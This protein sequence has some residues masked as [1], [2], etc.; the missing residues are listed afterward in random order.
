MA[1]DTDGAAFGRAAR[2]AAEA[3]A[4]LAV[5]AEYGRGGR[6]AALDALVGG[7]AVRILRGES[8]IEVAPLEQGRRRRFVVRLRGLVADERALVDEL[9][10]VERQ[11]S[12]GAWFL[13][14]E[15]S[16]KTRL[17]DFPA[18]LAR[19]GESAHNVLDIAAAER[20]IAPLAVA[21][22][23]VLVWALLQPLVEA[24][25]APFTLR[26]H[27]SGGG[28]RDKRL[29]A[30]RAIAETFADLG[31]ALDASLAV[32]RPGA[33]WSRLRAEEQQAH[34][35]ALAAAM[36]AQAT[37]ALGGR[38]RAAR[39]C[40]LVAQHAA[41]ARATGLALRGQ[42]VTRRFE[43]T[44]AGFFG[45][46]WLAFLDYLGAR[47]HPDE[48]IATALPEPRLY[49]G[50]EQPM[51]Q[52]TPAGID[53][54]QLRLMLQALYGDAR[55]DSPV[56]RRVMVLRR[57][58][59]AFD[60]LHAA[61][62]P[63]LP[64][65]WGL[66]P[67]GADVPRPDDTWSPYQDGLY[68][69][70]LPADL[71]REIEECWGAALLPARPERI[72][73][74]ISA[75]AL[76]AEAF[77]PALRFWHGCA[78]TAWFL[79]EGPMSRTDMAG[80]AAYHRAE[81]AALD[82]LGTPVD[83]TLFQHLIAA[84]QHLG[85]PVPLREESTEVPSQFG[86]LRMTTSF[87]QRRPGFERLRDVITAARRA[88]AA[89]HLEAYLRARAEGD[90]GA[91]ARRYQVRT[92]ERGIKPPTPKQ[93]ARDAAPAANRWFGGDLDA[94][95]RAIGEKPLVQPMRERLMPADRRA[96][97]RMLYL[98]LGGTIEREEA[99]AA[100]RWSVP[101]H[102][103]RLE[104]NRQLSDLAGRGLHYIQ[105]EEGLGRRPRVDEFGTA[106]FV[107]RAQA[108]DADTDRAWDKY[109]QATALMR[110][111]E[112]AETAVTALSKATEAERATPPTAAPA[113]PSPIHEQ[114]SQEPWWRRVIGA[115]RR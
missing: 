90:V 2:E 5:E 63:G 89:Q 20:A 104:T 78:L 16:I 93:F 8:I 85:A 19:H 91:A 113:A 39:L 108:L 114:G 81:L 37:P 52:A 55:G 107:T 75:H 100:G 40:P 83:P 102:N 60:A 28:E 18:Q 101:G 24:L 32:L 17:L 14:D 4:L 31:F 15:A 61:Q 41:K 103:E 22:D 74:A 98:A 11:Q 44:L 7:L 64:P 38:Y 76:L 58:W 9:F 49:L 86:M 73:S 54:A 69:R 46:D 96:F 13:P 35:R 33:G 3:A 53:E 77:G 110:G 105:L 94:L 106:W 84:E 1:T 62:R 43:P 97:V 111:A 72:V 57:Y 30:W 68:A 6:F 45:G 36:A 51:A 23:V 95:Y 50:L 80:L 26:A 70:A 99:S 71:L 67:D 10:A 21:P 92:V 65:L 87:G 109:V 112:H 27:L 47:S 48:Q 34:L 88:W 29:A 115:M 12:R 56:A 42:V 66:V 25:Y 82:E 59:E 79:C